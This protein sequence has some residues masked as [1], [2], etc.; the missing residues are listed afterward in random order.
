MNSNAEKETVSKLIRV[1]CSYSILIHFQFCP[2]ESETSPVKTTNQSR[3]GKTVVKK[4]GEV[5]HRETWLATCHH[6]G[7]KILWKNF[8]NC[9]L[10][11]LMDVHKLTSQSRLPIRQ[12]IPGNG[13]SPPC[14][15]CNL[16]CTSNLWSEEFTFPTLWWN[17]C[18]RNRLFLIHARKNISP[19]M[20]IMNSFP[21]RYRTKHAF[22]NGSKGHQT[23]NPPSSEGYGPR[24]AWEN[25]AANHQRSKHRCTLSFSFMRTRRWGFIQ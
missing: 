12:K 8:G 19:A 10:N 22:L 7:G 21:P 1:Y 9:H 2:S 4:F 16:M 17:N 3:P 6:F 18:I 20:V 15:T 14:W 24:G 25:T 5:D 23:H 11:M 13:F